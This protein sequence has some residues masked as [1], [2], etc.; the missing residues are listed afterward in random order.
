MKTL[1]SNQPI[2]V[3]LAGKAGSGKTSVAEE[4]VPKGSF[5]TKK[6]GM[7]W[8]HIFFALPLYELAS[9]R[10]NIKGF[11][12]ESRKLHAIHN[13]VYEI[14]GGS[15]LGNM[16][17]YNDLVEVVRSI[18]NLPIEPEGT[19]PRSFLQK[20]GDICRNQKEEC[21]ASWGVIKANNLHRQY[22]KSITKDD[23]DDPQEHMGIIISDV[24]FVNEAE[25][26]LKQP[27]GFVVCFDASKETLNDRLLK[28]DGR[29]MSEEQMSHK[30]EQQIDNI[31]NIC[32]AIINTDDMT[33]QEQ[34]F[35]T[36]QTL[37]IL[38]GQNA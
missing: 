27:N 18:Y 30:S 36:L 3:G 19:K 37:G 4:I 21:F 15:P 24:R 34:T 12:E 17:H 13:V 33:I 9:I 38:Q 11:D 2:I 29:L 25:Y 5:A 14:F 31:K 28:R 22:I 32:S 10:R 6:Y 16:P 8:D 23:E 1:K 20:A 7:N 26:I 35:E